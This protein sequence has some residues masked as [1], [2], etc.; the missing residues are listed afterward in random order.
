MAD[1]DA[2]PGGLPLQDYRIVVTR[3]EDGADAL[4]ELLRGC[5]AR[6]LELPLLQLRPP[7][8]P[9]PLRSA[10]AQLPDYDW[11]VFTSANAVRA[12][13]AALPGRSTSLPRP[14][15]VAVVGDA[16]ARAVVQE[17]G[18]RVDAVPVGFVG[19]RIAAAMAAVTPL[20]GR[21]V[22]WPR[23][24]GARM[25][26][27]DDLEQAGARLNAPEAYRTEPLPEA[28]AEL[29]CRIAA[30]EVDVVTFTSPSS[31]R[32]YAATGADTG[33]ACVA[34]IGPSTAAA[35]TAAG[36]PVHVLPQQHTFRG[37]VEE[38]TRRLAGRGGLATEGT[39]RK[40]ET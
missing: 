35:A 33:A 18:W 1:V 30:A 19:D 26:L 2:L 21:S 16:T 38:L 20:A 7:H 22:L 11:V 9:T 37:L 6:V 4:A 39:E 29:A 36:I 24:A 8:D 12:L 31:V 5:G 15:W 40:Q 17:L 23:A 28:A 3:A 10:A 14:R 13:G 32:C 27:R 34:V 25:A